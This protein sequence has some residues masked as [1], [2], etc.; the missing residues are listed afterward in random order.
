MASAITRLQSSGLLPVAKAKS[1]VYA[2]PVD[3]VEAFHLRIADAFK[4][5][6]NHPSIFERMRQSIA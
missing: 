4:T 2:A 1:L 6:H 3:N 5:I